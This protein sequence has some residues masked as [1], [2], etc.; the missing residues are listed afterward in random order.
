MR[1]CFPPV[2]S[3]VRQSVLYWQVVDGS[4]SF[5]LCDVKVVGVLDLRLD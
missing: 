1:I 5:F 4:S 3:N 2:K